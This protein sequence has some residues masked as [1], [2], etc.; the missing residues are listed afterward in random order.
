[1]SELNFQAEQSALLAIAK[2]DVKDPTMP[3]RIF[4][5]EAEDLGVWLLP[6]KDRLLARGL[7]PVLI[8]SLNSRIG[9]LR[10]QQ[11][12]WQSDTDTRGRAEKEWKEQKPV[13]YELRAELLHNMRFAYSK[14]A[15]LKA[16]LA[17]IS[18]NS[19]DDDMVQDL[20]SLSVLGKKNPE[21]LQEINYDL[22]K[23]D[24]AATL[25]ET[26]A[27][28]LAKNNDG[29]KKGSEVKE[30]RDRAYAHL[31]AA[32]NE[33]RRYGKLEFWKEPDRLKGYASDH[34]R[35]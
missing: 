26:L 24:T 1:M 13:G 5:Q 15:K 11:G 9:A 35:K 16:R 25:S 2:E 27:D 7:D 8:D 19:S 21:P 12:I 34:R 3:I 18:E 6:D 10:Y 4:A 17:D 20:T 33:I 30:L 32:V 23:L 22:T 28:L 29:K 14:N 31:K